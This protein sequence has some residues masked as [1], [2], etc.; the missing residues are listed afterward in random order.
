MVQKL[1]PLHRHVRE[2][3][4]PGQ[5]ARLLVRSVGHFPRRDIDLA[6]EKN[7][8]RNMVEKK[9]VQKNKGSG[10]RMVREKN[11]QRKKMVREKKRRRPL[12]ERL[13]RRRMRDQSFVS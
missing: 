8:L 1:A 12:G 6:R 4:G 11:G 13:P 2:P 7:G 3:F 5:G 9:P 10:K